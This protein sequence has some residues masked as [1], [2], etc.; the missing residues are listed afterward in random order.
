VVVFIGGY[1]YDPYYG[2]YPWWP[3]RIYPYP[4]Y[5]VF[6]RRADVRVL[7]TPEEA[8]VYV[9]GF[10]AGVVDDFNGFFQ[11]LPLPPGG[12]DIA[13]YLEGYRTVHHRVYLSPGSTF[14]LQFAM[15]P[16]P[17]GSASE[18]PEVA[19]PVPPPPA[20]T[21]LPPRTPPQGLPP[22]A[23]ARPGAT[24]AE[25]GTLSLHVQPARAEVTIDGDGWLSSDGSRFVIELPAGTHRIEVFTPGYQ[26]F[27]TDVRIED[28]ET[29]ALN[30]SLLRQ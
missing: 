5:P 29:T 16:L 9:D 1:F 2:P 7:V 22:P 18:P 6:D 15:E 21:Y 30:V 14:K 28:G 13:F 20:D 3:R 23:P 17:P 10:Y 19:P 8:A 11:R 26:R 25:H 27:S 24:A 12:H 4:Y